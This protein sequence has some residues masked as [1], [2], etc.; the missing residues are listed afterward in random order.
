[1]TQ[2]T[3]MSINVVNAEGHT[4]CVLTDDD[5]LPRWMRFAVVRIKCLHESLVWLEL[6][7]HNPRSYKQLA[8]LQ[9]LEDRSARTVDPSLEMIPAAESATTSAPTLV[10]LAAFNAPQ[11][12][13]SVALPIGVDTTNNNERGLSPPLID[14][15]DNSLASSTSAPSSDRSFT[16]FHP[17]MVLFSLS[18]LL[19]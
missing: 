18:L 19:S 14:P 6:H 10:P 8:R 1:M 16:V 5:P 9:E 13:S 11:L 4:D 2:P 12:V 17:G 15:A 3:W 7:K